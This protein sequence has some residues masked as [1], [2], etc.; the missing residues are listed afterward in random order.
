MLGQENPQE[1]CSLCYV[2]SADFPQYL[3]RWKFACFLGLL[4]S[5]LI[6]ILRCCRIKPLQDNQICGQWTAPKA[7]LFWLTCS[8]SFK[9]PSQGN[10]MYSF[11]K[12]NVF[13]FIMRERVREWAGERQREREIENSKQALPYHHRAQHGARTYEPWDHGLSWNQEPAA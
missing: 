11:F 5:Y 10:K 1:V 12:K 3:P 2:L 6:R 9:S 8:L 7:T 13:L 4:S